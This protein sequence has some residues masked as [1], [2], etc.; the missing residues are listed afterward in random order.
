LSIVGTNPY[1]SNPSEAGIHIG[2][3][4]N[5]YAAI[6]L[7]GTDN[8]CLIDFSSPV[9]SQ[10]DPTLPL[11]RYRIVSN[12]GD[13]DNLEFFGP[14]DSLALAIN[15][16][17][18]VGIGTSEPTEQLEVA[19]NIKA[20]GYY[21]GS[22]WIEDGDLRDNNGVPVDISATIAT[23]G[24]VNY[25]FPFLLQGGSY[26]ED[27][28]RYGLAM[29]YRDSNTLPDIDYVD[30]SSTPCIQPIHFTG[31]VG[32]TAPKFNRDL[33]LCPEGGNVGIGMGT[34]LPTERLEVDGNIKATAYL[35]SSDDR[36]KSFEKDLAYG[37]NEISQIRPKEYMKH[38]QHL[39]EPDDESG[40]TL[41]RDGSGNV[42]EKTLHMFKEYGVIAQELEKI[43][44]LDIFV[45]TNNLGIKS[46]NYH[47]LIPVMINA[48]KTLKS[49]NETLEGQVETMK[50][51]M[52]AL[53]SRVETLEKNSY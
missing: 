14:G 35:T 16:D 23:D 33:H 49:K 48:I 2:Q 25:Q 8:K 36:L 20:S 43:H 3:S 15:S 50:S 45:S 9:A 11:H 53:I 34:T 37:L 10:Q 21:K 24:T 17:A 12:L 27:N 5:G 47:G 31:G 51:Q 7:V 28:N 29:Y 39:V 46:V 44:G 6:E 4:P 22:V 30:H 42:V 52:S 41:P 32:L 18:Y 19:G 40:D 38:P 26:D 1:V 13:R